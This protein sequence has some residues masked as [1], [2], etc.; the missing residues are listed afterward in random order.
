MMP[1]THDVRGSIV[2]LTARRATDMH[3]SPAG[4]LL[5]QLLTLNTQ[6]VDEAM[7]KRVLAYADSGGH[8]APSAALGWPAQYAT[9]FE[10]IAVCCLKT[11][12]GSVTA[13]ILRDSVVPALL[14]LRGTTLTA[15]YKSTSTTSSASMATPS[16]PPSEADEA[17]TA[18]TVF[19]CPLTQQVMLD[20]VLAGDGFIYERSAIEQWL[21][22][23]RR[24]SP[25]TNDPLPHTFLT[26]Q[27]QLR[28]SIE[29]W[30]RSQDGAL[31]SA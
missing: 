12:P 29:T 30:L 7:R 19:R 27:Q 13:N 25:M 26:A 31:V 1:R 21:S 15:L 11:A 2:S 6:P 24:T 9:A 18:P 23:G 14:S 5:L 10:A 22:M 8:I 16:A 28:R 17:R 4:E 3:P 20:P